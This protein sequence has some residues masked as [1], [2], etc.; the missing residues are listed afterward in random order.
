MAKHP[1]KNETMTGSFSR[2][3]SSRFAAE[4]RSSPSA[5]SGS[6]TSTT[7]SV[8]AMANTASVKKTTRSN[9]IPGPSR[10]YRVGMAG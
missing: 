4:S 3:A 2:I 1:T 9:S 7:S 5:T 6:P 10:R 8:M